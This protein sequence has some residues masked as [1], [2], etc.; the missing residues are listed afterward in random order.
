MASK[1]HASSLPVM[2]ENVHDQ[3][4]AAFARITDVPAR[5]SLLEDLS[6]EDFLKDVDGCIDA[7]SDREDK[8]LNEFDAE[9]RL[10][11]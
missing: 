11:A 1:K 4:M 2:S 6:A 10:C 3:F 5:V 7:G 8:T 9:H